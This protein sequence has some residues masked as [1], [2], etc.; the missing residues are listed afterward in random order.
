MLTLEVLVVAAPAR[1]T[2][3][4]CRPSI[5]AS[6]GSRWLVP[7]QRKP[8]GR[9]FALSARMG[10]TCLL[11]VGLY[12]AAL[13]PPLWLYHHGF[14]EAK[15]AFG[16]EAVVAALFALQYVSLDTAA[17]RAS[18]ARVVSASEAPQLHAALEK[19]A[20]L[21]DI[22]VPRAALVESEMPNAFAAGRSPQ[23]S[24]IAITRG[25]A[26]R[27]EPQ[28]IEAV[29]AHEMSHIANRDG[30]VMTFAS[31]PALTLREA[32]RSAPWKMWV[33]GFPIM[34][35]ACVFYGVGLGIMLTISRCR[36]YTAD[37]GAAMLTGAP[38]QLMAALQKIAGSISAIPSTDLRTVSRMSAFFILPTNLRALT[39][40]PIERRLARLAELS[41]ELGQP[42]PPR[43]SSASALVTGVVAFGVTFGVFVALAL[44]VLR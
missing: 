10:V 13:V 22:P 38:E 7:M 15:L 17:L 31:F 8:C 39:H 34:V 33:F 16:F 20:A 23:R 28:E 11:L 6:T 12:L 42:S 44:L 5:R 25:L 14:L 2:E 26:E 27:L 4:R 32:I 30:A 24:T 41:R 43:A 36:E 37:R 3:A 40:P 35:V 1:R 19:L 21:A 18:R 29:L 9:D